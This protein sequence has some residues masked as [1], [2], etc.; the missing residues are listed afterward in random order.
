MK[1]AS[2][3]LVILFF[4]TNKNFAQVPSDFYTGKWDISI[5]GSPR[6][7][8]TFAT[9]LIRKDGKLT[10]VLVAGDDKRPVTKIEEN[11][12]KLIIYFESSQAGEISIDLDKI[13]NDHLMGSLM[14]YKADAVRIKSQ[15]AFVGKWELLVIGTPQGDAKM[16]AHLSRKEGKLTGELSDPEDEKKEKIAITNIEEEANKITLYF[17]TSGYDIN[18]ALDKVD[19]DNLKGQLMGMFETK[20]KRIK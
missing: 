13:D 17:T 4:V 3:V 18:V 6:G 5:V 12:K 15:D 1:K 10:G 19:D 11:A 8:I 16:I 14:G 20:A 9:D 7:D 2:I